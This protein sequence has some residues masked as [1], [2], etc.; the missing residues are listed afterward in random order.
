[1][2]SFWDCFIDDHGIEVLV[3][4]ITKQAQGYQ[5]TLNGSLAL[6]VCHPMSYEHAYTHRGVK[7]LANLITMNSVPLVELCIQCG[8]FSSLKTLIEAFSSPTAVNCREFVVPC[9]GFTSRHVYHLILLLTQAKYLR[10]IDIGGNPGL[11]E[12]VPL[13][14]S[15]ARNLKV[16][17]LVDI[18]IDDQ[19]L[20]EMAQVLQ[21][22]TSL[23]HLHI[24]SHFEMT[25]TFMS[26]IKFVEIV[27]A[28]ESQSRL[29]VLVFGQYKGNKDIVLLSYQLTHMAAS[30]G[31]KLVVQPVCLLTE[32]TELHNLE[33]EQLLKA[34]RMPDSLL[35][36]KM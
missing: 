26:L 16:M 5:S 3:A 33:R 6:A 27:T 12:A 22:N 24:E 28:R 35:Y 29:E 31:H 36:G 30:R 19:E 18:P 8:E 10:K 17:F 32:N 2:L 34:G 20:L 25:Y 7:A 14:L 9:N 23:I 4:N 1:M 11:H 15:A 13:L 21:S